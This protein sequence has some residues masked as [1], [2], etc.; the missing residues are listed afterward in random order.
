MAETRVGQVWQ[1]QTTTVGG[2]Q[3]EQNWEMRGSG[4]SSSASLPHSP[5]CGFTRFTQ[6]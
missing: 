2:E 6:V 5:S 3:K 4:P 1:R